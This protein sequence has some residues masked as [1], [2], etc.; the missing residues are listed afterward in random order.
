MGVDIWV[1]LRVSY[2]EYVTCIALVR[3]A[4]VRIVK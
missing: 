4:G 2:H 1:A 3:R